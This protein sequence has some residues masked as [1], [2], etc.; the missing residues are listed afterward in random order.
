MSNIHIQKER[1]VISYVS[2][3]RTS[4]V[5]LEKAQAEARGSYYLFMSSL[6]FSA[7][8]LE[9]FL[10]HVGA[11]TFQTWNDLESL[12]PRA[13]IDVVCEKLGLAPEWGSLPWQIVPEII[14]FRNKIAHGKNALLTFEQTVSTDEYETLLHKFLTADWQHYATENNAVRVRAQLERLFQIIHKQA[15]IDGDILFQDGFQSG[16]ATAL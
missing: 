6:V 4:E 13:K 15:A 1:K 9:A 5:L 12:T 8:A 16:T 2:F 7:F 3:W 14:G 10:N 11:H